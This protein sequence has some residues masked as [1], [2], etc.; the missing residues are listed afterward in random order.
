MKSSFKE[1]EP[2]KRNNY[3]MKSNTDEMVILTDVDPNELTDTFS[4]TIVVGSR[5]SYHSRRI[6]VYREDWMI[7]AFTE[8][9]GSVTLECL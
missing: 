5:D 9:Y 3:L 1:S 2:A 4:G 6:G 8:V 7:I